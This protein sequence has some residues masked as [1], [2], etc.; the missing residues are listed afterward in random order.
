MEEILV[1]GEVITTSPIRT[2]E[3]INRTKRVILNITTF[4][5]LIRA[6]CMTDRT[7]IEATKY[8]F[9]LLFFMSFVSFVV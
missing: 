8:C 3:I 9:L 2:T 7:L 5:V 4:Y 1:D 6:L